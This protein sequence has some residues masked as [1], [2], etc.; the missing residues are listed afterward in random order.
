MWDKLFEAML[1]NGPWAILFVVLLW[2]I[3]RENAK[4]EANYQSIIDKLA[5]KLEEEI[6]E[7]RT[8]FNSFEGSL[9][10]IVDWLERNGDKSFK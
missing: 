3:L 1:P 5:N 4:R 8:S 7:V 2:W 10:R 9:N 6:K